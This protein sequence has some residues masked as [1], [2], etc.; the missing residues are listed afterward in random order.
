MFTALQ[1]HHRLDSQHLMNLIDKAYITIQQLDQRMTVFWI[2]K[3]V[4][5]RY[6]TVRNQNFHLSCL[7]ARIHPHLMTTMYNF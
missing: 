3:V 2:P 4:V 6:V 1:V 5:S 7:F